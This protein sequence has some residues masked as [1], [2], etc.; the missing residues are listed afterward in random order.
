LKKVLI[1]YG[2]YGGGHIAA[3]NS[4]KDYITETYPKVEVESID[5]IEYINKYINKISTEAYKEMAKKTPH[6]WE[7]LY[8][9]SN[10]GAL[11]KLST[12]SNKIMAIR[13]KNLI[14]EQ[15]P[16]LIISTHPFSSQMCAYLKKKQKINCKLAT[17]MTDF[18]IHNQW[19]YL[20]EFV[21]YFFVSNNQMKQD[22][23]ARGISENKIFITGIPVSP[24]FHQKFN[25]DEIYDEFWLDKNKFTILFFGGGEFGL[26][27]D[28]AFMA[29]KAIIRLLKDVQVV[30]V[31]GKNKK[32]NKKFNDLVDK[33][34]SSD[35]IKVLEYTDKVPELMAI[36]NCVVTKAGGLTITESLTSHL[37]IFIINPIPGQEEENSEFLVNSGCALWI[38]KEDNI[39]RILKNLS[40]HP[41]QLEEMKKASTALSKPN[42]TKD[43]CDILMNS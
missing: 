21:D 35:R 24:K 7:K 22:I 11:A 14:K 34:N 10:D 26:G 15:S 40:R 36:A 27:R 23:I 33:T 17:V 13:L 29:L 12:T 9:K 43:I 32:M 5:C 41:E 39:A 28:T 37:P 42:A 1:F 6:L 18:H 4:I 20:P 31:S 3:A 8:T 19:L 25:L 30:A 16:D 2:T 38:K